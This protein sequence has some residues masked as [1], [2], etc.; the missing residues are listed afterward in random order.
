M[1]ALKWWEKVVRFVSGFFC[2]HD[3]TDWDFWEEFKIRMCK[4]CGKEEMKEFNDTK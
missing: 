4:R 2:W 3:Y 1:G